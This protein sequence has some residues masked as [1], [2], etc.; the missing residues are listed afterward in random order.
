MQATAPVSQDPAAEGQHEGNGHARRPDPSIEDG[1]KVLIE[2]RGEGGYAVEAPSFGSVH[3]SGRPYVQERG[4]PDTI[5]T[6]TPEEHDSLWE[7]ARSFDEMPRKA[8]D[9]PAAG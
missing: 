5:A 1:F 8:A 2:T 6:I 9:T 4:G 7:L 3:P